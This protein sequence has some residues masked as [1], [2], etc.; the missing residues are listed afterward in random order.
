MKL[1]F[2]SIDETFGGTLSHICKDMESLAAEGGFSDGY[3]PGKTYIERLVGW[4]AGDRSPELKTSEAYDVVL[5]VL[6][7]ACWRGDDAHEE[8][9]RQDFELEKTGIYTIKKASECACFRD[10]LASCSPRKCLAWRPHD[11]RRGFCALIG[12]SEVPA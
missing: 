4:N 11:S 12:C 10:S 1:T 3:G 7:E 9:S 6:A 2:E 8:R 5:E